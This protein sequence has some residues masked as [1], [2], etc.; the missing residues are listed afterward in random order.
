MQSAGTNSSAS[1]DLGE[2][3]GASGTY[4]LSGSGLLNGVALRIGYSGNGYFTQSGGVLNFAVIFLGSNPGSFGS[5][6]LNGPELLAASEYV[7]ISGTGSFTQSAGTNSTSGLLLGINSGGSGN[8]NLSGSGLLN[9]AGVEA[10]EYV[11]YSGT[12]SFTQSGGTNTLGL[13]YLGYNAGACGSYS[14]GG[15]AWLKAGYEY[16]GGSGTG[17][18]TQSAGTNAVDIT[19]RNWRKYR[20]PRKLRSQWIGAALPGRG[21]D[22]RRIGDGLFYAIRRDEHDARAMYLGNEPREFR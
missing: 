15:T 16:V 18:F 2:N 4:S 1:L 9:V 11:G 14:L 12:G 22:H 8:Y 3:S 6:T 7:G 10:S 13:L 5:Y 21:G 19:F 17:S 20:F